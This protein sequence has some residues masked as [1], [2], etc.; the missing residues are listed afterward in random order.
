MRNTHLAREPG[1]PVVAFVA[2]RNK[3]RIGKSKDVIQ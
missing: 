3:G 1:G 2:E